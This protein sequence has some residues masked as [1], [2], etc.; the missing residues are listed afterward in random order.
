MWGNFLAPQFLQTTGD[1]IVAKRVA[2]LLP[3]LIVEN[4]LF[5]SGVIVDL[6]A[7]YTAKTCFF[8]HFYI[9]RAAPITII[10]TKM[11]ITHPISPDTGGLGFCAVTELICG[12]LTC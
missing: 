8:Q 11:I 7:H 12:S 6:G 2:F 10:G 9:I 3:V 5:G 4:F 1:G